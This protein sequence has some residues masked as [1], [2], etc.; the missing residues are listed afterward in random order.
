MVRFSVEVGVQKRGRRSTRVPVE[1][2][3]TLDGTPG[4]T[5]NIATEG[6]LLR[7]DRTVETGDVLQVELQLPGGPLSARGRVVRHAEGLIAL[8]LHRDAHPTVAEFVIA[9]KLRAQPV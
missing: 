8:E 1:L 5:I 4:T 7:C 6:V 9:E 2:A 3:I